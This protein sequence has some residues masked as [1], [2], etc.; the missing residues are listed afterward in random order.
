MNRPDHDDKDFFIGREVEFTPA[1]GRMTLFVV[2]VQS[3]EE[4]LKIV[5]KSQ[6]YLDPDQHITHIYFGANQSFPKLITTDDYENWH[7]WEKMID[8]CL[9][10]N[11]WC[12]LDVHI[13]QVE[14]LLESGFCE[15]NK[16]IPIIS[17]PIPYLN[18]LGYN[19]VLKID[20]IDFAKT[21][22]GVWC[23]QLSDLTKR[24]VFTDWSNYEQDQVL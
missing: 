9:S 15:N 21:N 10:Q 24:T 8:S 23:H 19:A 13:G 16:F 17:A 14:G 18:L 4:I 11:L 20:D 6:E 1:H 5:K 7:Q 22:P 12:S 3:V 2:G